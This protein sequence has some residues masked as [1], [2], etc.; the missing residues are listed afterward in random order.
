VSSVPKLAAKLNINFIPDDVSNYFRSIIRETIAERTQKNIYRPDLIN[1]LMQVSQGKAIDEETGDT[2]NSDG[3]ATAKE[4]NIGKSAV[5]HQWS[6][7]ELIAQAFIFFFAGFETS[8]NLIS[9]LFYEVAVNP[10]N[11]QET[12][13]QEVKATNEKLNGVP[14]HYDALQKMKYMDQVVCEALRKWPPSGFTNRLCV[15]DYVYDDGNTKLHIDKGSLLYIPIFGFQHDPQYF[16]NPQKFDPERFSDENKSRIIPGTYIPFGIGPRNCIGSRFALMQTKALLF[17]LILNFK[18]EPNEK[19]QIPLRL[20]KHQ[21]L[22]STEK[23]IHLE[24][25]PRRQ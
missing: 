1:I 7:D 22:L 11:V 5:K 4:S 15:K 6:E 10:V 20:K 14:I 2:E 25:T 18:L 13:Y 8:S 21:F 24:F 16:P 12:L 19:T 23:G 3:F 9:F 17:Y